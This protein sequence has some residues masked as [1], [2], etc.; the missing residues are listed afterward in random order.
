MKAYAKANIFLKIIGLDKRSYHLINSRFILIR[1]L[2]DEIFIENTKTKEGFEIIS[3]FQCEDNIL[4]KAYRALCKEGYENQLK[5]FFKNKSIKLIKNIP[6]YAGLGGG[7]SDG[8]LFLKMMNEELNLKLNKEQLIKISTLIGSDL[9]FFISEFES[10]NVNGCGEIIKEF[11]DE[12]IELDF[13]FPNIKCSTI[14]V[15]KE[16]DKSKYDF[17]NNEIFAKKL[18][19]LTSKEILEFKNY[20]LNDL[21]I[22]CVNLYDNM[23]IFLNNDYFLSG[24][25]SS[26]FKVKV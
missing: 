12:A 6:T 16:F 2:Y 11:N 21:F 15:Y 23:K 26:I 9:A 20:Q 4:Y 17:K 10:A 8:A 7:S 19:N 5:E 14:E 25:G 22:P 24:S 13:I 1:D 18:Q 3:N